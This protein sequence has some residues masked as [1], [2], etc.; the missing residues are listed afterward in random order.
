MH[1]RTLDICRQSRGVYSPPHA[2]I[3]LGAHSSGRSQ[4]PCV[5]AQPLPA[6][7]VE[8]GRVAQTNTVVLT[9]EP[10]WCLSPWR[11]AGIFTHP[12]FWKQ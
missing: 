10:Q 1:F 7:R 9:V 2:A 3:K 5:S 4:K 11:R 6:A 8:G 12:K